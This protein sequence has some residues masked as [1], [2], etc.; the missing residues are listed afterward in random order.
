MSFSSTD[1]FPDANS[2]LHTLQISL[3][4]L[5]SGRIYASAKEVSPR[6]SFLGTS[7]VL[8]YGLQLFRNSF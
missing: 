8:A 5:N 3:T 7:I 6:V 1:L 4:S 2:L